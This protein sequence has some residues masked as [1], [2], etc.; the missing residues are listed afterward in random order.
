MASRPLI[1]AGLLGASIGVP[2]FTSR[3]SLRAPD[4]S[5]AAPPPAPTASITGVAPARAAAANLA[6]PPAPALGPS[7]TTTQIAAPPIA[8]R[9]PTAEQ[10]LRF[11]VTKDW[12]YRSWDRKTVGPTDLGLFSVRVPFV[13]GTQ[14]ASLAGSLTYYFNLNDKVEHISFHGRTGDPSRLIQFLTKTYGLS[15]A[16]A[17]VGEY[18]YQVA[19]RHGVQSELRTR[20]ESVSTAANRSYA[21]T[22]ELARPG[23]KRYLPPQA[24]GLNIPP[25]A[26]AP[27]PETATAESDSSDGESGSQSLTGRLFD[28]FRFASPEEEAPLHTLRWPD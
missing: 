3:A 24:P 21:V 9:S 18:L 22:L 13:S 1:I 15:P 17:P 11:D 19:D 2:Y 4:G 7:P 26:S 27:A 28:R 14:N 10:A 23:S 16:P 12:V 6:P 8:P 25:A 20:E 5:A